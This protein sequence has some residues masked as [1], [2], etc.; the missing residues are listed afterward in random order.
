MN[1]GGG[2]QPGPPGGPPGAQ[3]GKPPPGGETHAAPG[4]DDDDGKLQTQEPSLPQDPLAIPPAAQD[5]IGTDFGRD[6]EAGRGTKT[7]RD[8]YGLYYAERS[9]S[10]QFRTVFPLWAERTQPNDRASLFGPLYFQR[11]STD[12]DA[13]VL[14]PFFWKLRDEQMYTTV[15]GPFMHRERESPTKERPG[16]PGRHDN[17]FTPLFMEG[18]S[19]DGSGYLHIPPLLTFTSHTDRSGFNLV[20]PLFC[21]WKGGPACDPRT[22]DSIDMGIAP[23]YFYGRDDR[24]EYEIIP[25]LLH[26]YSYSDVGDSSTNIWGPFMWQ[27]SR[28]SDVFNILPLFWHNWGKN[29]DHL[30][31]FPFFHQGHKG[32]S[33][34]HVNPLFLYAKGDEGERTFAS[35]PFAYHRGRTELTMVTPLFWDYRDPDIGLDQQLLF[36]FFYRKNS[37]RQQDLVLFPFYGSFHKPA[38]SNE[39]WVTPFFRHRTDVTGWE[40]DIMPIFWMGREY[41]STHLVVAPFLWDFASPKSRTTV[42]LPIFFR[43]EDENG[44]SQLAGNTYYSEHKVRGGTEWEFHFFPAFSYG[45]SPTGHWWNILYGLAGYTREGT[46]A[47]M[48]ALFIPIKLSE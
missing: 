2:G 44:I 32:N 20:G 1:F 22:T 17:W 48:R 29:E 25:P 43:T 4:S 36:P 38:I 47:K 45:E 14:F 41:D 34:L 46:M 28:E 7:E 6:F 24:S 13:D 18:G 33:T 35:L 42:V 23:L 31:L 27:H 37:P 21:K 30:T 10:Y 16:K 8:F 15:V 40:T 11:R 3:P 39:T 12:V 26:Y 19:E 5:V 9:G